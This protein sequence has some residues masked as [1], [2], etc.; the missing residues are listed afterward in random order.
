MTR[1]RWGTFSV[2]DHKEPSAFIPEVLLYD[3]L[4]LPVPYNEE[5]RQRWRKAN[6]DPDLLD[7]RLETLG[8][9]AVRAAWDQVQ[10][11]T[12]HQRMEQLE[13]VRFDT[14][15]IVKNA[16]EALPYQAT[17]MILAEQKPITLPEGVSHVAVVAAYQ[18]QKDF[19]AD[20]V[21]K[22]QGDSKA[23]LGLLLGQKIAV[24]ATK[25]EPHE[26]LMSAINL[27]RTA[28]FKQKRRSLYKWQ[29]D[30]VA[31]GIDPQN[32]IKEMDQLIDDYNSCVKKAVKK[33]YYKYAFTVAG[34]VLPGLAG[35]FV[36]PLASAGAFLTIMQFA[37][38]DK[39]PVVSA[40]ESE[41]AAMFHDIN[42]I[43]KWKL[44]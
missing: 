9:L 5:D 32:A 27:T 31:N 4:V 22:E 6:W 41:P 13:K 18:S 23:F 28:E 26:A 42:R 34:I 19:E 16:K 39:K 44:Y 21:L 20:F 30:V 43:G 29:E 12:F 37:L 36:N 3:R 40:G 33:V 24:P 10:Q 15:N 38:F 7:K 1:E 25:E 17:R 2:I 11:Q 8:D 14:K 35:A